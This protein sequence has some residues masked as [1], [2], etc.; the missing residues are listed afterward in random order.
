[1]TIQKKILVLVDGS[2]RSNRTV[3]Y[4]KDFLP[5]DENLKIVLFHVFKGLPE[6]YPEID[7][8]QR[9][10]N[11]ARQLK[12]LETRQEKRIHTYL[13]QMKNNLIIAGFSDRQ[14]EIKFQPLKE[15]VARD[16]IHEARKGYSAVVMSRRGTAMALQS[17]ILGSVAVKLL[18]S[19]SFIPTIFVG[20]A[21]PVKKI[22]LAVDAS[23]ASMKAVE[24]VAS[25]LSGNGYEVC[26]IHVILG[27]GGVNFEES[28]SDAPELSDNMPD[29]GIESFKSEVQRLFQNIKETLAASGFDPEKI[30]EKIVSGAYSRSD[31]IVR[32][33]EDGGC[34]TIV[35]GRRGLSKVEAFFMGRVGHKVVYGGKHFSVWVV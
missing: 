5:V 9:S 33:A 32:E 18:Q 21:P 35:V 7:K 2:E 16:I 3:N 26:I 10:A 12:D 27:L 4:V 23:P 17:I 14:V 11:S 25:F 20:P 29:N 8:D 34:S 24:F 31:T 13:E 19:I 15:G 22:L 30:S 28:E 6:E 1:M